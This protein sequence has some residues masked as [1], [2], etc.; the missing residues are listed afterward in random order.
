LG[1]TQTP[2]S[3]AEAPIIAELRRRNG[4]DK[5][6]IVSL[7][8]EA[9]AA[10]TARDIA[11]F[12]AKGGVADIPYVAIGLEGY[13]R[14]AQ[15]SMIAIPRD[16]LFDKVGQPVKVWTGMSAETKSELFRSVGALQ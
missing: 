13:S 15:T 11:D 2:A 8:I 1:K 5:L 10:Q 4:P 7:N 12:R 6:N 16:Y 9:G 3:A 14:I